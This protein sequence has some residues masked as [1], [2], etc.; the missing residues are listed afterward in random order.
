MLEE[1]PF[2]SE[3]VVDIIVA[4]GR[5]LYNSGRPYWH[6][7]ETVNALTALEPAL[8]RCCQ[9]AWDLAFTWLAEEPSSHH[10]ALPPVLLMAILGVCLGWGWLRESGVF[11]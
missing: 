1:K 7:S 5:D 4:Y 6:F 3:R 9:A 8:R 2:D 10:I 11:L